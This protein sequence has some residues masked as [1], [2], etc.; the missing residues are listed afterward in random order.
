MR[1]LKCAL[2]GGAMSLAVFGVAGAEGQPLLGFTPQG[3]DAERALEA[4]F[5]SSL[6]ADAMR[7]RLQQMAAE[8]NHVGSPH[9]RANAEFELAQFKAWGW[10]ARIEEFSVLYP[11]PKAESLELLGDAPYKA[12][13]TEPPVPGDVT[14]THT[15]GALPAWVAYG[16]DGDVTAPLVYVNYGMPDDYKALARMGVDV[17]GKIVIVRYGAGWR[18]LK[19]KLAQEHGAVGC[20]I[21]SDPADDGYGPG[22]PYPKGAWRNENGIQRGSVL[23]MPVR[24][25]DPLTPDVGATKD[26]KRIALADASTILKIPTLP[27]SYGQAQHFLAALD[28]PVAPKGWRGA[29]PLTYHVGP[30]AKVHM[31]VQAD[32]SQ[33]PLY[34]VIAVMKGSERPDEWVVRGNHRDGW[35]YG[36]EDPL[37]GQIALMDEA[38]S[39]GA[40]AKTGW[41]P[42]RT[43]VYA[44]WDGEEPGLLG[45]TEWAEQHAAELQAKAVLYINSDGN[46]RGFLGAEA[47][48]SLRALLDQAAADVKDPETGVSVRDRALAAMSV[49]AAEAGAGEEEKKRA[50]EA[51]SGVLPIGDLGSGSDYTPF[52]QHL[53]L[54]SINLG[55]GGEGSS[56]GVYHSAYDTF[57]HYD[58]FGDP[59]FHYGVAL[60]QTTGRLVLRTADADID[61]LRFGNLADTIGGQV[62]ELKTLTRTLRERS[63]AVDKL[64]DGRAYGLAADPTLTSAPPEREDVV[65]EI[66]FK[67]LDA[68]AQRLK[69]SASA[70]DQAAAAAGALKPDRRNQVNALLQ[71][72]EQS[73]TDARGLPGRPWYRHLIYAPGL[74]T[75]YGSKTLP[76]VREALESRRWSEAGEF[77]GRTAAVLQAASDR[78]DKAT[79]LL[80][81]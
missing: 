54:A 81:G 59:G 38:K 39:L 65:P 52:V 4:R 69:A 26:A 64:L 56:G 66:D 17:K 71:G 25:G 57:E 24:A 75:G 45:S 44:S 7:A 78:L 76:G 28:G 31:V 41:R 47:S 32:W 79:A 43:I 61:P 2:L 14:S 36:A 34:D 80:K 40:L 51:S 35:V 37:S 42:K 11:T 27:I 20:I 77:V 19:P 9:D 13:L 18:G 33:K 58:R 55:F 22:D 67:A 3:S 62:E 1:S 29:L 16:G 50:K 72:V 15:D 48:Y 30:G 53:G 68:A 60:A 46:G 5:D 73:L 70:Y 63:A 74:L 23:D 21:Y 8:P 10:D 49:R 12:V 6:S